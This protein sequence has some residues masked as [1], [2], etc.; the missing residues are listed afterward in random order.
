MATTSYNDLAVVHRYLDEITTFIGAI[1]QKESVA[2]VLACQVFEEH[3]KRQDVLPFPSEEDRGQWLRFR[4]RFLATE[5]L[6]SKRLDEQ[7]QKAIR[8]AIHDCP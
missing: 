2:I 5:Y 1:V 7:K 4:S 6:N 8:K 3:K